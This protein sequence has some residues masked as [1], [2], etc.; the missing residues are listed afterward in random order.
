MNWLVAAL[1][2]LTGISL[3]RLLVGPTLFDRLVGLNLASGQIVLLL[4]T[5]AVRTG[6]GYYLDVAMIY[7]LLSFVEI[8]V[9]VRWRPGGAAQ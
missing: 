3:I 1:L 7:A 9:F 6:R 8:L 4:C 5:E 2:G